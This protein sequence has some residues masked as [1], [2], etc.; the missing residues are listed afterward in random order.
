MQRFEFSVKEGALI[1]SDLLNKGSL[2][3]TFRPL[4]KPAISPAFEAWND[5]ETGIKNGTLSLSLFGY[6][7]IREQRGF[8]LRGEIVLSST[9]LYDP[10]IENGYLH[11]SSLRQK[12]TILNSK[13]RFI[14]SSHFGNVT[15]NECDLYSTPL[16]GIPKGFRTYYQNQ[17]I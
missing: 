17:L 2:H 16:G 3:I 12:L 4:N 1:V 5:I 14:G 6:N 11:M 9:H 7:T 8:E 13:L 15:F 10:V